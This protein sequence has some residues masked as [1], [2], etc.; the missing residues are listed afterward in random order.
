MRIGLG[1]ELNTFTI[2]GRCPRTHQLGISLAT[3]SLAVGGYCPFVKANLAALS[4]QAF[5][6]PQLG[7]LAMRLLE[8][9]YSPAKVVRELEE[10]DQFIEYRQLGIV[11]KDGT[12]AAKT[13]SK[14]RPWAGHIEGDGY[15]AMGNVLEGE[16]VVNAMA[17]AFDESLN[18][19]LA[20][21][22][23]SA[24][25]AGRD[26]GGQLDLGERSSALIVYDRDDQALIDLR[27]DAND[28]PVGEL[29]RTYDLYKH[30]IPLYDTRAKNPE[31]YPPQQ[32]WTRRLQ[33]RGLIA[34][35]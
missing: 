15:V 27:V 8:T 6:N 5:A 24:L 18:Q 2:I 33:E 32:E 13:G 17:R 29:R 1:Q 25:A 22:L 14:T 26:A 30:Y 20:V 34:E 11:Y 4:T 23:L 31:E 21:R 10:H 28:N 19:D 35:E 7:H 9:G 16:H 12:T 3:Y